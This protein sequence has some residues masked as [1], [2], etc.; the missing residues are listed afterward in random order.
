MMM[1]LVL[2]LVTWLPRSDD[3]EAND[4]DIIMA[5]MMMVTMKRSMMMESRW[6][7]T[8]MGMMMRMVVIA[9]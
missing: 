3:V 5:M 4:S 9:M 7:L 2:V 1:V 8:R 6:I